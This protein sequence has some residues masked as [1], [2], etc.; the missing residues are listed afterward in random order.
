M[1]PLPKSITNRTPSPI[2]AQGPG[3]SIDRD[4]TYERPAKKGELIPDPKTQGKFTELRRRIRY[5]RQGPG[6][7]YAEKFMKPREGASQQTRDK[8]KD[9][10]PESS[11]SGWTR[12]SP[13]GWPAM[14]KGL[15]DPNTAVKDSPG[16]S[17]IRPASGKPPKF[18]ANEW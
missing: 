9:M 4:V 16:I 18:K 10:S 6:K 3:L 15:S 1:L 13:T 5:P 14:L 7:V 11:L 2:S 17:A 8:Y 12:R